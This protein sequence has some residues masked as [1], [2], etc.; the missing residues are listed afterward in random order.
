M[1]IPKKKKK[2]SLLKASDINKEKELKV[3]V[4][5]LKDIMTPAQLKSTLR[6]SD[7]RTIY[8]DF[9]RGGMPPKSAQRSMIRIMRR[10]SRRYNAAGKIEDDVQ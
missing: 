9:R 2:K 8:S 4:T 3:A 10:R 6:F 1:S 5:R 7:P